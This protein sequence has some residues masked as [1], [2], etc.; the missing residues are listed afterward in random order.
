MENYQVGQIIFL[1]GE[2]TTRVLPI[3]V[4]EEVVRTTVDGKI[5][6]YTVKLPDQK[7][8]TADIST[9]KGTIF[10]DKNALRDHMTAN[11]KTAI[12]NMIE[13][14]EQLS[15][16][17]FEQ[18]VIEPVETQQSLFSVDQPPTFNPLP[19]PHVPVN[20]ADKVVQPS[21]DGD[22]IKV[23]LGNGQFANMKSSSLD[24]IKP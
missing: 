18:H 23:D 10:K 17:A 7:E 4:V 9:L 21:K 8:T 6:T 11:A 12:S 14:A 2:K 15:L 1:I 16:E 24:Q 20:G 3:Q 22:I 13:G 19:V 5:K